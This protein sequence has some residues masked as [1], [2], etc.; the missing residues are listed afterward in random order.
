[1]E[2]PQAAHH[3]HLKRDHRSGAD[4]ALFHGERDKVWPG[5]NAGMT[6]AI[7][8]NDSVDLPGRGLNE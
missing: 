7:I 5:Q 4:A 1:M 2:S 8:G 3:F 6:V